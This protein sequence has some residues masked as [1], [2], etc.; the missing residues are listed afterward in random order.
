MPSHPGRL[1]GIFE[2]GNGCDAGLH[3]PEMLSRPTSSSMDDGMSAKY[4]VASPY[5][6]GG[7][8][9]GGS[10]DRGLA[11]VVEGKECAISPEDLFRSSA[12][13]RLEAYGEATEYP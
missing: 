13:V 11:A 3:K 10:T 12:D 5:P 2:A 6:V 1:G 8:S 7:M 9:W 4:S